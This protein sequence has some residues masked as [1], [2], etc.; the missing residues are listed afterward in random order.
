MNVSQK[1]FAACTF[2]FVYFTTRQLLFCLYL[3]SLHNCHIVCLLRFSLLFVSPSSDLEFCV[4]KTQGQPYFTL[5]FV[6][7]TFEDVRAVVDI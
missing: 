3:W 1:I 2:C 6:F 5:E 7:K 4:Y